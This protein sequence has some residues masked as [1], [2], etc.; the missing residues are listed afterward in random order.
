MGRLAQSR[1]GNAG[2]EA[3]SD[4]AVG[5]APPE[6]LAE[7]VLGALHA[8]YAKPLFAYTLRLSGD[9]ERSEEVVQETLLRAWQHP[10]AVD[11]TRGSPRAW[12]FT[13]ARNTLTDAWRR[14]AARPRAANIERLEAL[15][16]PDQA[17]R[18]VEASVMTD[19]LQRLT[20]DHRQVLLHS[21]YLGHS[22]EETASALR[23]PAGTVKS[24]TYYALRALRV[25]LEEMG[26]MQ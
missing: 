18:A 9:R 1:G 10:D 23:V 14:D 6:R 5:S 22:V 25:V 4:Q 13:V 24:R 7:Q 2:L 8:L 17:E 20:P 12:L 16:V 21:F 3:T 11:G 15:A 19:G 26:Y